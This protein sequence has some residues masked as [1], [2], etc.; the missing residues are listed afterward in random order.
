M[1]C[2]ERVEC[3]SCN[4]V[5][6]SHKLL[7][8]CPHT[9]ACVLVLLFMCPRRMQLRDTSLHTTLLLDPCTRSTTC[10]LILLCMCPRST[11]YVSSYYT[12]GMRVSA[13]I[14]HH[15]ST[16]IYNPT[17]TES[18]LY[19]SRSLARSP[20]LSLARSLSPPPPCTSLCVCIRATH[21]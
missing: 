3:N 1:A 7:D 5:T 18:Q 20:F 21:K 17:T 4:Y 19:L 15:H 14:A 6:C 8:Q 9:T 12:E 16:V 10:V 13:V 11:I 2:E